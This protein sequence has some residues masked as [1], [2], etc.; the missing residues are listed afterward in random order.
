MV[1]ADG[2]LRGVYLKEGLHRVELV[3]WP[4][5]L[6]VGL[7]MAIVE[8]AAMATLWAVRRMGKRRCG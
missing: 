8:W 1:R 2:I 4:A 3:Y 7:G 6:D 5:G